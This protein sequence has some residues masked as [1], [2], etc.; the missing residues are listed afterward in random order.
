MF[1]KSTMDSYAYPFIQAKA[2]VSYL[3][4]G[5]DHKFVEMTEEEFNS[6]ISLVW[7]GSKEAH[8]SI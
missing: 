5:L 3:L 7:S 8:A 1:S 4:S 2:A 6:R